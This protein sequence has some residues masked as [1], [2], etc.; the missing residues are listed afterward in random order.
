MDIFA[1]KV[2]QRVCAVE[3]KQAASAVSVV[4]ERGTLLAG[5]VEGGRWEKQATRPPILREGSGSAQHAPA[6]V[7]EGRARCDRMTVKQRA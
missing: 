2:D 6:I 5:E 4:I 7:R 3:V 1:L